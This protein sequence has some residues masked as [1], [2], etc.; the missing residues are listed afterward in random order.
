M[1]GQDEVEY[2]KL[3]DQVA[4]IE[5]ALNS[6]RHGEVSSLLGAFIEN[7]KTRMADLQESGVFTDGTEKKKRE[8][9]SIEIAAMVQREHRL[10][11]SEKEQYGG[12]LELDYFTKANF[13]ELE[14]FY[15]GSWDK[16]SEDGKAQ[17][18]HRVWEGIRQGEYTFEELPD[19]VRKKEAE[20]LYEQLT[21]GTE[22][23]GSLANIPEQDR[24]DFIREYEAGND[25]AVAE[26]LGRESFSMSVSTTSSKEDSLRESSATTEIKADEKNTRDENDSTLDLGIAGITLADS[27]EVSAPLTPGVVSGSSMAK[28]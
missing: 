6:G 2:A 16:L 9:S 26:V 15:S 12:F 27:S 18:S 19:T 23:T 17:M 25:K 28:G 10:S 13:G 14:S 7:A 22:I 3:E 1:A 21:V 4:T 8:G 24:T 5:K 20:R 11:A